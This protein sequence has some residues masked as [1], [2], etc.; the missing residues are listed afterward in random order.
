[1]GRRYVRTVIVRRGVWRALP[2]P[3]PVM[4]IRCTFSC[5]MFLSRAA[6]A[7]VF[8]W[9]ISP[10]RARGRALNMVQLGKT[11]CLVYL[12]SSSV[13]ALIV[14]YNPSLPSGND[15]GKVSPTDVIGVEDVRATG[16]GGGVQSN[17]RHDHVDPAVASHGTFSIHATRQPV[18]RTYIILH[19]F[20]FE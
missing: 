4:G 15:M 14:S 18:N 7:G 16:P 6:L 19:E 20:V 17:Q 8:V 11:G 13:K 5:S 9:Y 12:S 1:M 3:L 2:F 10:S